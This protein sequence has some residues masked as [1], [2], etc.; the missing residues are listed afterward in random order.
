MFSYCSI[1]HT[2]NMQALA[3]SIYAAPSCIVGANNSGLLVCYL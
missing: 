3:L 2:L 1:A